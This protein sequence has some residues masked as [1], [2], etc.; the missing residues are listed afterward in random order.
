MLSRTSLRTLIFFIGIF[1]VPNLWAADVF[2]LQS[3][4]LVEE[5]AVFPRVSSSAAVQIAPGRFMS[6]FNLQAL[7]ERLQRFIGW[8]T[9]PYTV[10][11]IGQAIADWGQKYDFYFELQSP[12]QIS[13]RL[14]LK[15]R[16]KTDPPSIL[17]SVSVGVSSYEA[18]S[19]WGGSPVYALETRE[20]IILNRASSMGPRAGGGPV[21]LSALSVQT[22]PQVWSKAQ[23]LPYGMG[24]EVGG[25][26]GGAPENGDQRLWGAVHGLEN[27][28]DQILSSLKPGSQPVP[29]Q[30]AMMPQGTRETPPMVATLNQD[31]SGLQQ[32]QERVEGLEQEREQMK[33]LLNSLSEKVKHTEELER[34]L[35]QVSQ[36][37]DVLKR[38]VSDLEKQQV[39]VENGE[40]TIRELES[41]QNEFKNMLSSLEQELSKA[42]QGQTQVAELKKELAKAKQ[43]QTY[44]GELESQQ[45]QMKNLLD[46]LIK[47]T[48]SMR[49]LETQ[50]AQLKETLAQ[51]QQE[52]TKTSE[53][54]TQQQAK[55]QQLQDRLRSLED[56]KSQLQAKT[57][58]A[59]DRV[60]QLEGERE[61]MKSLLD[62][63]DKEMATVQISQ[64]QVASLERERNDLRAQVDVLKKQPKGSVITATENEKSLKIEN[65]NLKKTLEGVMEQMEKLKMTQE[66]FRQLQANPNTQKLL[67]EMSANNQDAEEALKKAR[68][69]VRD[70]Q[71]AL[72]KAKAETS[73]QKAILASLSKG[74]GTK[75]KK[76][77]VTSAQDP[78]K[79][80]RDTSEGNAVVYIPELSIEGVEKI[81][82]EIRKVIDRSFTIGSAN[83]LGNMIGQTLEDEGIAN[84]EVVIPKQNLSEG[85][86]HMEVRKV[87]P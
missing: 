15:L 34:Q 63:I 60:R 46:D 9:N 26:Q 64:D 67:S 86:V 43:I 87:A 69:M 3:I 42:R 56:E 40:V 73:D 7:N 74:E 16:P 50:Q 29:T 39:N 5:G 52:R 23:Q 32:L 59:Q 6:P 81:K 77:I 45:E 38:R 80:S 79:E 25:P 48:V 85:I 35:A 36:E 44:V 49:D 76:L 53:A 19:A 28:V 13:S 17:N 70:T 20:G 66:Q 78:L 27:K 75:I 31:I 84:Y 12:A 1:F 72:E 41:Q 68:D 8:P 37:R 82:E 62:G 18:A 22:Y 21:V 11:A 71:E 24:I 30:P 33:D 61:Q 14:T 51:L 10:E 83:R 57:A 65:A 55:M 54:G 2:P 47:G 4:T 58:Q